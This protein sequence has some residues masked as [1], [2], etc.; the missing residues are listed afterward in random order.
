MKMTSQLQ[1]HM[2]MPKLAGSGEL[3]GA[4]KRKA[5]RIDKSQAYEIYG[6]PKQI[7]QIQGMQTA[8]YVLT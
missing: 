1:V 7:Y 3:A 5:K 6:E 4:G 8:G 2:E